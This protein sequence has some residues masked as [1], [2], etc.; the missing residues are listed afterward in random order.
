MFGGGGRF[1]PDTVYTQTKIN[2][3]L[4]NNTSMM[5]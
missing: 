1:F 2:T 5:I 3:E 4:V